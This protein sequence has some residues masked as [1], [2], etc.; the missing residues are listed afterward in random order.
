MLIQKRREQLKDFEKQEKAIKEMKAANKSKK[1]AE[2]E[3]KN[4]HAKKAEK[5]KKIGG[6]NKVMDD[7]E[8]NGPQ[9]LLK[10]PKEYKVKF[11]F[12]QPPKL[13]PPILGLHDVW[14]R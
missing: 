2:A 10:K 7:D 14:F 13:S 5:E 11:S 9:E 8:D 4:K 6:K 12:P 1:A 3:M